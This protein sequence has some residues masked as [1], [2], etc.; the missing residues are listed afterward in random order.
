[1][2][3]KQPAAE[4]NRRKNMA[5]LPEHVKHPGRAATVIN[6]EEVYCGGDRLL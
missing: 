4:Q 6:V 5:S 1:M 2:P 3:I